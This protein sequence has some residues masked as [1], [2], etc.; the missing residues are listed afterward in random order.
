MAC[1]ATQSANS[2]SS[3]GLYER[4]LAASARSPLTT[5]S[6]CTIPFVVIDTE[7]VDLFSV[8]LVDWSNSLVHLDKG[9][10]RG[11]AGVLNTGVLCGTW[12]QFY[13]LALGACAAHP[14]HGSS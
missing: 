8:S 14:E 6:I 3:W 5:W 11:M 12:P 4:P 7:V 13:Q 10:W 2:S 9:T 1:S